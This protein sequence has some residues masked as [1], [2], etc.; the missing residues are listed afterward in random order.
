MHVL[1]TAGSLS[2][3]TNLC[4]QD[5]S[6]EPW[7]TSHS[8]KLYADIE[9]QP[10]SIERD[11]RNASPVHRYEASLDARHSESDTPDIPTDETS[12]INQ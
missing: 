2:K 5:T 6:W 3:L 7:Q 4:L 1:I 9:M 10:L 11:L 12:F 8:N